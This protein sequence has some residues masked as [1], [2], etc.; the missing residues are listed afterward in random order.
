MNRGDIV[1]RVRSYTRDLSNSIFRAIDVTDYINEGID[2]VKS[3]VAECSD[4]AYL[5][6][7]NQTPILLPAQYHYLLAVYSAS[8]CFWQDERHYQAST[9]MNEFE[10]KLDELVEAIADGKVVIKD[11]D[12]APVTSDI[13]MDYVRDVYFDATEDNEEEE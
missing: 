4:M 5:D 1:K 6:S 12:G 3:V 8:R 10:T 9:L 11:E 2:R 13:E 7:D